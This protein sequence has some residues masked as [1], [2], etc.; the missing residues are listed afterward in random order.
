MIDLLIVAAMWWMAYYAYKNFIKGDNK[1]K[2][3]FR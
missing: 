3:K 1:Y 2:G